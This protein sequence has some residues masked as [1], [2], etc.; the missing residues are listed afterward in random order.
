MI[1]NNLALF[2]L[3]LVMVV[4]IPFI[5]K[6]LL[7]EKNY[8]IG[9]I[10]K[11][12]MLG[13]FCVT[14][15]SFIHF[16]FPSL[17]ERDNSIFA[18][19]IQAFFQVALIEEFAKYGSLVLITSTKKI[20]SPMDILFY[21][22]CISSAFTFAEN[23]HYLKQV[24]LLLFN[25]QE[26]F[27]LIIKRFYSACLI[28]TTCGFITGHIIA[29]AKSCRK[30]LII[31]SIYSIIAAAFIHGCYDFNIM[32]LSAEYLIFNPIIFYIIFYFFL[33]IS[34]ILCVFLFKKTYQ[35][36]MLKT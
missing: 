11:Y 22:I 31:Y 8:G 15:L 7:P 3:N 19:F 28:H 35:L 4:L 14:F 17:L 2:L 18:I 33:I 26:G 16:I 20:F 6:I 9:E 36:E 1:H 29:Y 25:H 12:I 21:S 30:N 10:I 13:T 34:F 5:F 32:L 24:P 23:I 27:N